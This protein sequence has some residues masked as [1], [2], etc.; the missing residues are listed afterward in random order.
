MIDE[1]LVIF[2]TSNVIHKWLDTMWHFIQLELWIQIIAVNVHATRCEEN[3]LWLM[4]L[5]DLV[6]WFFFL[7]I[8]SEKITKGK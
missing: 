7:V 6:V 8:L 3:M 1:N 2:G 4:K 5:L